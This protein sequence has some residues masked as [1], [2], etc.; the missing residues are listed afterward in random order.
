MALI[1]INLPNIKESDLDSAKERR[2]IIEYLYALQEQLRYTL[3]NLGAEN[4]S[5]ELTQTISGAAEKA[6]EAT[7]KVSD[8]A[9]NYSR[10]SQKVDSLELEVKNDDT[11]SRIALMAGGAEIS[12]KNITMKGLVAF[13]DLAS[14][15]KTEINGANITTG[16]VAASHID[17][18]NLYAKHLSGADGTFTKL[19]AGSDLSL[20]SIS[21]GNI[22]IAGIEIGYV[23]NSPYKEICIVPPTNNTGNLGTGDSSGDP[24]GWNQVVAAHYNNISARRFKEEIRPL[25]EEDY[26]GIENLRPVTYQLKHSNDGRRYL[27]F[28]A[29]EVDEVCPLLVARNK[30]GVI[31]GLD[32]TKICVILTKE[33]QQLKSQ[34]KDMADCMSALEAKEG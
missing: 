34:I 26:G 30:D 27:G 19:T 10:I 32:Y 18:D 8:A 7:R 20:V 16:K 15:G 21:P 17:V 22:R 14:S 31:Y 28:I 3:S 29:E 6:E 9:G 4:L 11:S 5:D 2:K 25:T 12:A 23:L 1:D 33:I 24:R 13:S